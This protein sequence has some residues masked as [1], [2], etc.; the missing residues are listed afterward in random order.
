M[1]NEKKAG[2]TNVLNHYEEIGD[3]PGYSGK[4]WSWTIKFLKSREG[5]LKKSVPLGQGKNMALG[6]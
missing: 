2:I 1:D 4:L 6:V 3:I 5:P